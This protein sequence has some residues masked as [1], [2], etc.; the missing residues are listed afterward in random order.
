[1]IPNPYTVQNNDFISTISVACPKC[2]LQALVLGGDPHK[3]ISEYEDEV[4]FSCTSCGYALKYANTPKF[5]IYTN[6]RGK[7]VTSRVL[8]KNSP[9][10]PY[11][12]FNVWYQIETTYGL[13]WAYNLDHLAVIENYIADSQRSRNGLENKNNSIGSRLPQW[14]KD[15]KNRAYLLKIIQRLKKLY[16]FRNSI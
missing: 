15:S 1:M 6:S 11:F 4:R 7:D 5:T 9:F 10:D 8:I 12:G 2:N 16:F 14:V 13:L 3:A